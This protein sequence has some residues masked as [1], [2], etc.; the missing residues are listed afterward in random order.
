MF[1]KNTGACIVLCN[2]LDGAVADYEEDN[3]EAI[4]MILDCINALKLL[5]D[6]DWKKYYDRIKTVETKRKERK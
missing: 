5:R 2:Y 3:T 4:D 6:P 1:I